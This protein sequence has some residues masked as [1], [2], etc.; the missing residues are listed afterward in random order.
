[1]AK[2]NSALRPILLWV[3]AIIGI[4]GSVALEIGNSNGAVGSVVGLIVTMIG[5][6]LWTRE[7]N[8]ASIFALWGLLAPIGFLGIMFLKDNTPQQAKPNEWQ[9]PKN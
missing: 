4:A 3:G 7:K 8:R 6:N 2:K 5:C 1:M 9:F